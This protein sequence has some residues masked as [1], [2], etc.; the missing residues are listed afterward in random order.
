MCIRDSNIDMR[1]QVQDLRAS[2]VMQNEA[3]CRTGAQPI[4]S[5]LCVD[6]L[7]RI[8]RLSD[9]SIYGVYVNPINVA[10]ENTS[11]I[12]FST[13]L[14]IDT[15]IGRFGLSG[16]YTWVREHEIQVYP[17]EPVVDM[18]AINS[19][20]DIPRTKANACLLYTSRCV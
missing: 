1:D 6:T 18:F 19:G 8:T 3:A 5:P 15:R 16:G 10:R 4:D 9:G 7:S 2:E 14:R 20:Y 11:G 13:N 17:D 12:D